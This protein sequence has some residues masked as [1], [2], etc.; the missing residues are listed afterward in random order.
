VDYELGE[1]AMWLA[2]GF[3]FLGF[4]FGPI[5]KAVGRWIESKTGAGISKHQVHE[6]ESRVAELEQLLMRTPA[7]GVPAER[8]A[9]LEERLDFAERILAREKQ[10]PQVPGER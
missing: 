7:Q 3:G 6:L 1:F 9:E 10:A 2:L 8:V 4:W 5:A